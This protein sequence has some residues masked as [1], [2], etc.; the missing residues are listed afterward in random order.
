MSVAQ[1]DLLVAVLADLEEMT[2]AHHGDCHG[3]D[4]IFH[5]VI[6]YAR[7]EAKLHIHPP[8]DDKKR[9]YCIGHVV[10]EMKPYLERNRDIVDSCDV[11]IACPRTLE[12]EV[13]SGTW[14]TVRYARKVGKPIVILWKDGKYEYDENK[15][16]RQS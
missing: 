2:E 11:L 7:P 1:Y 14:A 4:T 13:R 3:A 16:T 5:W 12:E 6:E 9:S 8:K 15:S 10:Y